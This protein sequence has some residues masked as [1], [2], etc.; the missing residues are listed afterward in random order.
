MCT[1]LIHSLGNELMNISLAACLCQT[2]AAFIPVHRHSYL[3]LFYTVVSWQCERQPLFCKAGNQRVPSR[4]VMTA[5]TQRGANGSESIA[6][7]HDHEEEPIVVSRSQKLQCRYQHSERNPK[8]QRPLSQKLHC[9]YQLSE[10]NPKKQRPLSMKRRI[11]NESN[12]YGNNW[13]KA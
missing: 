1:A 13:S 4:C 11:D 6:R 12:P 10:R 8:K 5:V 3:C 9:R 2:A 7:R